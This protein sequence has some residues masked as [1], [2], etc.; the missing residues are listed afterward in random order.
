LDHGHSIGLIDDVTE[1]LQVVKNGDLMN[2]LEKF[3][4]YNTTRPGNQTNEKYTTKSKKTVKN[5]KFKHD[6]LAAF[7]AI[8]T[9]T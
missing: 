5:N 7:I 8:V 6:L 3:Y 1:I 4:V 9:K 2:I